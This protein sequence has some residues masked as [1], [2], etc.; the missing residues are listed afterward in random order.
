VTAFGLATGHHGK[1]FSVEFLEIVIFSSDMDKLILVPLSISMAFC[2][3][4][5]PKTERKCENKKR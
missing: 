2:V 3:F 5:V 1:A 4:L